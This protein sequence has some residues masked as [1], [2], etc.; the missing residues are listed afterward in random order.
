MFFSS[1]PLP[2]SC[3]NVD[4]FRQVSPFQPATD[5]F[6]KSRQP[7]SESNSKHWETV[8]RTSVRFG[9]LYKQIF[10][11]NQCGYLLLDGHNLWHV[12]R[13]FLQSDIWV[14][15]V[16]CC[17]SAPAGHDLIVLLSAKQWGKTVHRSFTHFWLVFS[18]A[19]AL[20]QTIAIC[21]LD[22]S[23]WDKC[24]LWCHENCFLM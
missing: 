21:L 7:Y 17:L 1:L 10:C 13:H 5:H 4:Y 6:D 19:I 9:K 12:V 8:P 23:S 20:Q 24:W 11:C 22:N 18:T 14:W 15:F 16:R 2:A 3:C